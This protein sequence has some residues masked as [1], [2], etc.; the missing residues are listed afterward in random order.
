M[1]TPVTASLW[2][3][4]MM[5]DVLTENQDI[6]V[7]FD[8]AKSYRFG[9]V[10]AGKSAKAML[11]SRTLD[12]V[13]PLRDMLIPV[14]S[15]DAFDRIVGARRKNAV[16][17][18]D[19]A[20]WWLGREY[21]T[22][23]RTKRF[24]AELQTDRKLGAARMYCDG[25]IFSLTEPYIFSGRITWRYKSLDRTTAELWMWNGHVD[26]AADE[27]GQFVATHE[28]IPP[29]PKEPWAEYEAEVLAHVHREE[30]CISLL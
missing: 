16:Y 17:V 26:M 3:A 14:D 24:R 25:N 10:G 9:P 22:N 20:R 4:R 19:E 27:Y 23:K 15:I 7:M 29:P 12:P 1:E 30:E 6:N 5:E 11:I 2:C 8:S 18:L 28:K 21:A 13:T